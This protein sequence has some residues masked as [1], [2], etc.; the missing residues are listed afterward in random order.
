MY[1]LATVD[2]A[3]LKMLGGVYPAMKIRD[4]DIKRGKRK[5]APKDKE[6]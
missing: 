5:R 2:A 6:W 3:I 1:C 4:V